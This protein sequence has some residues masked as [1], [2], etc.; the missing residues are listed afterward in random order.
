MWKW[1]VFTGYFL[2]FVFLLR[3]T[4]ASIGKMIFLNPFQD[5]I[6][7]K[8]KFQAWVYLS[9]YFLMFVSLLTGLLIEFGPADIHETMETIH[10]LSLYYLISFVVL[11]FGG[12]WIAEK[13]EKQSL[14]SK[15]IASKE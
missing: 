6:T 10:K 3:L 14:V 15:M 4:M 1:H 9:F 13:I 11:H 7:L 8:Q 12:L 2:V 5:E